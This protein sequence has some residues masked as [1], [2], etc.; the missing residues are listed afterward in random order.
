MV[1]SVRASRTP[2]N[3]RR[4]RPRAHVVSTPALSWLKITTPRLVLPLLLAGAES[5]GSTGARGVPELS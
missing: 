1:E 5:N 3:W 2:E 4:S